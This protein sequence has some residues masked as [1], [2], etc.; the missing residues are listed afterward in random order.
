M[1]QKRR[2][3]LPPDYAAA[4]TAD[5][6]KLAYHKDLARFRAWGGTIPATVKQVCEYLNAHA[7]THKVSTLSRWLASISQAHRVVEMES[8]CR[9]LE[10]R[11]TLNG[12]KKIHGAKPRRVAPAVRDELMAMIKHTPPELIG[13]RNR[14]LLLVGFAGAL[15][16]SELAKLRVEDVAFDVRGMI[17]RLGQ[18]KTDQAGENDEI[19]IPY[20]KGKYCPVKALKS[21]LAE[22]GI[23]E[24]AIFRPILKHGAVGKKGLS[25]F[26]VAQIIKASAKAAGLDTTLYSGHS[27]RAGLATSSAREKKPFHKIK[28][29]TRHKSD[30]TL[31][32]Y[33]RDAELFEDNAADLL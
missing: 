26:S 3:T 16:R 15:R 27:L 25:G 17:L 22:A 6:T 13:L 23:T 30:V 10:V 4:A 21:W 18:T 14:A 8:P 32:K 19:A 33:I 1:T 2:P 28:T 5:N 29:Q 11:R 7:N 20:A 31:L 9:S 24:G 12:I